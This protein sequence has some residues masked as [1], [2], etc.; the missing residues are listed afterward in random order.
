MGGA[1]PSAQHPLRGILLLMAAVILFAALDATGKYLA[2][3]GLPVPLLVWARYSM[4]LLLMLLFVAP[5][6]RTRP[7]LMALAERRRA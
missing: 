1:S 4:H 5:S 2:S 6:M 3:S 7:L